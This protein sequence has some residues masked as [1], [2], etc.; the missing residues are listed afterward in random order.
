MLLTLAACDDRDG[1]GTL[2]VMPT[3]NRVL[4]DPIETY[5]GVGID[6]RHL[7]AHGL[8]IVKVRPAGE[9]LLFAL[10]AICPHGQGH[11]VRF[12]DMTGRFRCMGDSHRFTR[13]GLPAERDYQGKALARVAVA[14][15]D[16]R[17]A[18][19]PEQR[20]YFEKQEWSAPRSMVV[21]PPADE[22]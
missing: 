20:Y 16:G 1:R 6:D 14:V 3:I 2:Q 11:R 5:R 22:E 8:Y 18:I 10:E 21:L 12:D 7:D 4:L 13:E 15:V 17:L 19:Y 9:T